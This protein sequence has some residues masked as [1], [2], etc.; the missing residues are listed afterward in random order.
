MFD[1]DANTFRLVAMFQSTE[2]TRYYLQGVFIEPHHDKGVFL[3]ATDGHRMLVAHDETGS[4]EGPMIVQLSKDALKACAPARGDSN[5]RRI[6]AA[7]RKAE[8]YVYA[9]N[10]LKVAVVPKW[11]IE[12]TFPDWR[13]AFKGAKSDGAGG[14]FNAS[15]LSSFAKVGKALTGSEVVHIAPDVDNGPALIRFANVDTSVGLLMPARWTEKTG[16]PDWIGFEPNEP[17]PP[18]ATE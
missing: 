1:V 10:A 13:R 8:A 4:C 9:D 7:S 12:G 18:P 2:E 17:T 16:Y 6:E 11:E 5:P 14:G 3:V 15:Y